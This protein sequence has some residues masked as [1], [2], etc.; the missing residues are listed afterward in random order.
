MA[1]DGQE[2]EHFAAQRRAESQVT[3][4]TLC[5]C[6]NVGNHHAI[7]GKSHSWLSM[8]NVENVEKCGKS[9]CLPSWLLASGKLTKNCGKSPCYVAGKIHYFDWT[10]FNSYVSLPEGKWLYIT[11]MVINVGKC[12]KL[13]EL[14]MN[15]PLVNDESTIG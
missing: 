1:G 6:E 5:V 8:F 3:S 14:L 13:V 10:I 11:Y 4:W 9:P 15:Q 7:N 2:G 12:D